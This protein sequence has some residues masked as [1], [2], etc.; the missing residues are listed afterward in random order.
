MSSTG[1]YILA[2]VFAIVVFGVLLVM[3]A[4][5]SEY[6]T[7]KLMLTHLIAFSISVFAQDIFWTIVNSRAS[8]PWLILFSN[9]L[10]FFTVLGTSIT[11]T[12]YVLGIKRITDQKF[13]L[14]GKIAILSYVVFGILMI[15]ITFFLSSFWIQNGEM[16]P[17][18]WIITLSFSVVFLILTSVFSVLGAIDKEQIAFRKEY[19]VNA[20]GPVVL[21][22]CSIIQVIN[23]Y[24]PLICYSMTLVILMSFLFTL[25]THSKTDPL[26]GLNNRNEL[27]RFISRAGHESNA[28]NIVI[29]ADLDSFKKI[30]DT[31]GHVKGDEVLIRVSNVISKYCREAQKKMFLCRYGGDEFLIIIKNGTNEDAV[32]FGKEMNL[33]LCDGMYEIPVS[34]TIGY[35]EWN[36]LSSTFEDSLKI[37]D[38]F[39]YEKRKGFLL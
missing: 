24:I 31:Y 27:L 23:P 14:F 26:T 13:F 4:L 22:I 9:Y 39:M 35:A 12:L 11:W 28:E 1:Y 16:N 32:K 6:H 20:I 19:I 2:N 21:I 38:K 34:M 36:G 29:M 18:Y 25:T 33:I 17:L 10:M 3:N 7:K 30:N 15:P 8:S 37:A 5:R